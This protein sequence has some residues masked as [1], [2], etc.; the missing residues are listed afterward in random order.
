L[1]LLASGADQRTAMEQ[2]AQL[3]GDFTALVDRVLMACYRRQQE[4]AWTEHLVEHV[5]DELE[6]AGVLGRPERVPAMCF[7]DLA[8]YTRLTEE[9]GD[10]AAAALAATLAV[11]VNQL[12]REHGGVPVKW[13]GDG[14]MVHFREPAGAVLAALQLVEAFPAA[15]LPPAHVGVAAGPVVAQGGDYFGRT[16]N[17]AARI[18]AR[19]GASRVLVSERVVE[20]APPQGVSFVELGLV[21]LEG[22]AHPVR[23]LEARRT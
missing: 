9:R 1:P 22:I 18:A 11:L 2:A 12:S 19:A 16:V 21:Q 23:L 8:G 5:E 13:L 10:A 6:G 20:R 7:L 3:S 14:V 4:L 15:G 17:L